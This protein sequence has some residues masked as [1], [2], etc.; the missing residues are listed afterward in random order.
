MINSLEYIFTTLIM[1][2]TSMKL[3]AQ[4]ALYNTEISFVVINRIDIKLSTYM[5]V[6]VQQAH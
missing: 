1:S 2:R 5:V 3:S 6:P 4:K